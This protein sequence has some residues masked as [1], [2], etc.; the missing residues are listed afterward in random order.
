MKEGE[1][2]RQRTNAS[3]MDMNNSVGTDCGRGDWGER[4]KGQNWDICNSIINK[5]FLKRKEKIQ[6][7][8]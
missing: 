6:V 3:P 8:C 1:G 7:L 5:T 4:G 2:I